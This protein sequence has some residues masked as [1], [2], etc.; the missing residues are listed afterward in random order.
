MKLLIVLYDSLEAILTKGELTKRY[1]N[2]GN[3]FEEI[4][5][6]LLNDRYGFRDD[7]KN[8]VG[9]ARV[10]FDYFRI[11]GMI[12]TFGY[13]PWLLERHFRPVVG[14]VKRIKPDLIRCY[15]HQL[16]TY[17]AYMIKKELKIPYVVSL[18]GNPDVDYYRGRLADNIWK[19]LDGK[20]SKKPELL[21]IRNADHIIAVYSPIAQYL[22]KYGVKKYSVVYNS[23]GYGLVK[24]QDYSIGKC[25]RMINVGRQQSGQ[26]NPLTI[27]EAIQPLR[28]LELT[29]I[30]DGN[31]HDTLK[32]W[33]KHNHMS[34][35]VK[36]YKS[37]PNQKLMKMLRKFDCFVYQSDN[38]E[39]SK[40]CIEAALAG[41]PVI[42][43]NRSGRPAR[44]LKGGHFMLVSGT[45]KSYRQ[46]VM[47]LKS[48]LK[49]RKTLGRLAARVAQSR[50]DPGVNEAKVV[51][52]YKNIL[53]TK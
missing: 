31:L 13:C 24:K 15:G 32:K 42:A 4:Q 47:A 43:N 44:E 10:K 11:P 53:Q 9:K 48:S 33:V 7:L 37:M 14:M 6:L 38:Y 39:I 19:K 16:N 36:F 2:P 41:L 26:K 40:G 3:V 1:F 51:D 30:G 46:A 52:I 23:V 25:F 29:L 18:H 28:H 45:P 21:G 50:W 5:F 49:T 22:Q 34:D 17:C 8:Y 35:R 20:F 12:E 27:L